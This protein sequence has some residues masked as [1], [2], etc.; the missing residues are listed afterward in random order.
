M[1]RTQ[2]VVLSLVCLVPVAAPSVAGEP[3][4]PLPSVGTRIRV[5]TPKHVAGRLTGTLAEVSD[6]EMVIAL[7]SA[8]RRTIPLD[9]VTRLER[10]RGRHGH[11][12]PGAVVGAVLGGAFF[13]AASMALCDAASCSVSM[14]AVLVGAGLGALPGAG[15]GALIRTER[16]EE[17]KGTRVRVGVAPTR[18]GGV[19]GSLKVQF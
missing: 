7:S 3:P 17:A 8:E 12:A 6:R 11:W 13:G 14:T 18:G 16:W 5:T 4:L 9:G 2:N 19:A 15:I 10:S 1:G